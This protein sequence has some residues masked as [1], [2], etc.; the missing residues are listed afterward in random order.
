MPPAIVR[1]GA[2]MEDDRANDDDLTAQIA[3]IVESINLIIAAMEKGGDVAR[4]IENFFFLNKKV[5]EYFIA[6]LPGYPTSSGSSQK[7]RPGSLAGTKSNIKGKNIRSFSE[8]LKGK[9]G[10]FRGN[11]SGKRVNFSG[12]T[13]IS[14]DPNLEL[15]ELGVPQD[16]CKLLTFGMMMRLVAM[17]SA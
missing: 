7:G 15:D 13:V 11:L 4:I 12:R 17:F 2:R 9:F 14:P 8:R 10:R 5:S 3:K 6:D 16:V 1:P